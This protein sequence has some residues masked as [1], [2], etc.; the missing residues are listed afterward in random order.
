MVTVS[1]SARG[2]VPLSVTVK[3]REWTAGPWLLD[4]VQQKRAE[5]GLSGTREVPVRAG[6]NEN[7]RLWP[8]GSLAL[9]V[10]TEQPL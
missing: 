3:T 6:E 2:G 8:L 1:E 9:R 7:D 5:V 4:G 10:P